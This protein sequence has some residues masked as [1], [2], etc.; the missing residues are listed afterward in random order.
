M[1]TSS[2]SPPP[3]QKK[4]TKKSQEVHLDANT[5]E[6]AGR[7]DATAILNP[8]PPTAEE[9]RKVAEGNLVASRA[10]RVVALANIETARLS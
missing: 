10:A 5:A 8:T 3:A 7:Q 2:P 1:S 9:L 4:A 6:L